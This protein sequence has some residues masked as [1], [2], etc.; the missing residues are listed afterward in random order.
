MKPYLPCIRPG[1]RWYNRDEHRLQPPFWL[2]KIEKNWEWLCSKPLSVCL[3]WCPV[4]SR[5]LHQTALR[6]PS[7]GERRDV[8]VLDRESFSS[9]FSSFYCSP[10]KSDTQVSCIVASYGNP[11]CIDTRMCIV[12]RWWGGAE[13]GQEGMNFPPP[14]YPSDMFSFPSLPLQPLLFSHLQSLALV[15]SGF[16]PPLPPYTVKCNPGKSNKLFHRTFAK[17][18]DFLF[19]FFWPGAQI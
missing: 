13:G 3:S 17:W 10:E 2:Q 11:C 8:S 18:R 1:K 5:W 16:P 7:G 6:S 4:T 19:L 15:L 14:I 9:S 12:V